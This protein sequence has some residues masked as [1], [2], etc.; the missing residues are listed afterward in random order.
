MKKT[1]LL[2]GCLLAAGPVV[3]GQTHY[4]DDL[5][6]ENQSITKNGAKVTISADILMDEMELSRQKSL[7]L[8][9][10]IVSA[11]GTQQQE[12]S[13]IL[14]EGKVRHKVTERKLALGTITD[15]E[16]IMRIIDGK[17]G[18]GGFRIEKAGNRKC[19][20]RVQAEKGKEEDLCRELFFAFAGAGKPILKLDTE[21]ASLE[22]VFI[23]LTKEEKEDESN[24]QA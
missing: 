11:D 10:V 1:I 2:L 24:I 5:K 15:E 18:T 6:L 16:E 20:L 21:K 12:L 23:E 9:P 7:R 3:F 19:A 22:D 4:L 17:A 8:V 14:I 13:P